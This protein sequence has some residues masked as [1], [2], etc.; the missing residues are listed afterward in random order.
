MDGHQSEY[1]QALSKM[2]RSRGETG[3]GKP[4]ACA[5]TQARGMNTMK[6]YTLYKKYTLEE[7]DTLRQRIEAENPP[8]P[9]VHYTR[10]GNT[11][12][13]GIYLYPRKVRDKFDAIA[14]AITWHMQDKKQA[15]LV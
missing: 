9:G 14:Q 13:D 10:T 3:V 12:G 8:Q 1:Q 2:W 6:A 15:A 7:L 4:S 11:P 5:A